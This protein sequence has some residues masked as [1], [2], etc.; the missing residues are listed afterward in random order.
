MAADQFKTSIFT[1]MLTNADEAT[2]TTMA[3]MAS[4]GDAETASLIFETVMYEQSASE[5]SQDTNLTL[6]LLNNLSNMESE[7]VDD[8]FE[9]QED[10]ASNMVNTACIIR[11]YTF[12]L[13]LL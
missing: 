3:K 13:V 2:M 11:C 5:G 4:S 8:L 6:S 7:T 9:D 12:Y 1:E 10:L